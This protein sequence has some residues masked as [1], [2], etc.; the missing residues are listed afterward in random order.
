MATLETTARE[1]AAKLTALLDEADEAQS[2]L[3]EVR[4]QLAQIS[5]QIEADW[6]SLSDRAQ[7]LLERV[8]TAREELSAEA[9]SVN[10]GLVQLK[11]DV[12]AWQDETSQEQEATNSEI[13]GLGDELETHQSELEG[14]LQT[15]E[16][17]LS[18]LKEK[19][20]EV[21]GQLEE[22]IAQKE[23]Y[24]Q[25]DVSSQVQTHQTDI[26]QRGSELQAYIG[27]ESIGAIADMV[28]D[29]ATQLE[30][31]VEQLTQKK[32]EL[33]ESTETS[34]QDSISQYQ[35]NQETVFGDLMNTANEL[36]QMMA[37][38]S[39]LVDRG[40]TTV[41]SAK[42]TLVDGTKT[43]NVGLETALGLIE[44]VRKLL[45]RFMLG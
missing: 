27:D 12:E 6:S 19:V 26:E 17:S 14:T 22:E 2:G 40:G 42:D 24:L 44:E 10:E 45:E 38:L 32:Q 23:S 21:E 18:A 35:Q 39:D 30:D 11:S 16:S 28:A 34:A 9:D 5:E 13:T 20:E 36:E 31:K 41:V 7:S 29:L 25:N 37:Q 43:T 3:T 1:T 33:E 4:E 15:V 8:N